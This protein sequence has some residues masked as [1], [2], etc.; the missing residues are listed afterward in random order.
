[1]AEEPVQVIDTTTPVTKN[2][3]GKKQTDLIT[4]IVL[5]VFS[6]VVIQQALQM[7]IMMQYGPGAGLFPI[8]VGGIIAVLSLSMFIESI[9]PKTPDKAS[10]FQ[11]KSGL[12]SAGKL[13]IGLLVYV[14]LLQAMGY[15]I[16][17]FALVSYIL[18]V[19]EKSSVKSSLIAASAVTLI[20]FL[21]FQ[22]GLNVTL[23]K[24]P[25]G[26]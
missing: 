1:M 26:F 3:T 17:T 16:M 19:V 8:A 14:A 13:I 18:L 15:L 23:P 4:S 24:S 22:V 21:I 2:E 20:L 11:N 10:K 25:F 6:G 12:L 5:L 7:P 9:N